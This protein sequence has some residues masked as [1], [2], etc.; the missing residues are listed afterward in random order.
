MYA[1]PTT[2]DLK[3]PKSFRQVGGAE[4]Q[5]WG[6]EARRCGVMWRVEG[7]SGRGTGGHIFTCGG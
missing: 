3:K 5:R 1:S 7:S 6:E 4:T 2:K